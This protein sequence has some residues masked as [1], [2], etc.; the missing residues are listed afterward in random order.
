MVRRHPWV[1]V[2]PFPLPKIVQDLRTQLTAAL[3]TDTGLE[4]LD[5]SA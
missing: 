3:F 2:A 1:L 5:N 4:A